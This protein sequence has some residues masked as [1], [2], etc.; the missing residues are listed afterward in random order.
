VVKDVLTTVLELLG[1]AAIVYGVALVFVPAAWIA[2]GAGLVLVGWLVGRP[3]EV[4]GVP[5]R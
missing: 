1:L 4:V 3:A 5:P 2:A